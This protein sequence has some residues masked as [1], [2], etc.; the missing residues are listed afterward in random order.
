MDRAPLL[1]DSLDHDLAGF[2]VFVF[3]RWRF[4]FVFFRALLLLPLASRAIEAL[5]DDAPSVRRS[6]DAKL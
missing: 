1:A 4:L 3:L 5:L 2:F 6:L